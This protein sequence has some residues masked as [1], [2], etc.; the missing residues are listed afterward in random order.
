MPT[1][2]GRTV[3]GKGLPPYNLMAVTGTVGTI[4]NLK[5]QI[6]SDRQDVL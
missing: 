6:F 4:K 3:G 1:F 5:N 2:K